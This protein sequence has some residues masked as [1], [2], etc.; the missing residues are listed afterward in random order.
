MT[1]EQ[2]QAKVDKTK[3]IIQT[4]VDKQ[5]HDRCW[6]YPELFRQLAEEYEIKQTIPSSL[7]PRNE[8]EGGCLRYQTE[9]YGEKK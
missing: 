9:E 3:S 1:P 6:Y 5:G 7:P 2:L 8:F 4:W